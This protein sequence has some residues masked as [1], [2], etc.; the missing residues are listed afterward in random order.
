MV[1]THRLIITGAFEQQKTTIQFE[2][3]LNVFIV[4]VC[5]KC[6]L[7][8]SCEKKKKYTRVKYFAVSTSYTRVF[9]TQFVRE[10]CH[11]QVDACLEHAES[12]V[13][14][15]LYSILI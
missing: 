3:I 5:G 11:R 6:Q 2:K 4:A 1:A 9:L 14:H 15:S 13:V 10:L 7:I 8:V 12:V